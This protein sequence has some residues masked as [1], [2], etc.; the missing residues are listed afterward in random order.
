MDAFA[1]VCATL[2]QEC[3][4][5]GAVLLTGGGSG[6]PELAE[7]L[8]QPAWHAQ[9][10]IGSSASVR[11]LM[12]RDLAPLPATAGSLPSGQAVPALCLA[13][14]ALGAYRPPT[15]FDGLLRVQTARPRRGR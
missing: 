10:R 13:A 14:V 2:G 8:A 5:P 4:L 11:R 6:L 7:P 1:A 3:D 9:L 12:P 15:P